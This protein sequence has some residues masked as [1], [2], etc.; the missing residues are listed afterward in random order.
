MHNF[1]AGASAPAP[2]G[3]FIED[4]P[5]LTSLTC[6]TLD[7]A[8]L[9]SLAKCHNLRKL[10]VSQCMCVYPWPVST[11]APNY[12]I[13]NMVLGRFLIPSDR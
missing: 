12:K 13:T 4:L 3:S 2:F 6:L 10:R 5:Y 7:S 8:G 9:V 11:N 1:G